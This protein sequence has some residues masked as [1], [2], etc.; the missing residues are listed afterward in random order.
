MAPLRIGILQV[1]HDK[2]V[3]I[4][5]RSPEDSHRFRDRF[6]ELNTRVRCRV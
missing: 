3:D 6:D 5:D 2:S 1:N 4:G